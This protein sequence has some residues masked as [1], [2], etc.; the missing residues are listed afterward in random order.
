MKKQEQKTKV[1]PS[2]IG[3]EYFKQNLPKSWQ[4]PQLKTFEDLWSL[5]KANLDGLQDDLRENIEE[6]QRRIWLLQDIKSDISVRSNTAPQCVLSPKRPVLPSHRRYKHFTKGGGIVFYSTDKKLRNGKFLGGVISVDL[7]ETDRFIE[8]DVSTNISSARKPI[9]L[10][11]LQTLNNRPELMKLEEFEILV[12]DS[13]YANWYAVLSADKIQGVRDFDP[14]QFL[15]DLNKIRAERQRSEICTQ[16]LKLL[17]PE[18]TG[19]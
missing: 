1:P 5:G 18:I 14:I 11:K 16:A 10:K 6:L 15:L 9:R 17:R 2:S 7:E 13:A 3:W 8:F 4:Y 12:S 19:L